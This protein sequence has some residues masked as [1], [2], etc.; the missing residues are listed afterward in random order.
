MAALCDNADGGTCRFVNDTV[1]SAPLAIWA[2]VLVCVDTL[3]PPAVTARD[4]LTP[5]S[6]YAP[7]FLNTTSM[8]RF[9]PTATVVAVVVDSGVE[10]PFVTA[11]VPMRAV[12]WTPAP[13][14]GV[15]SRW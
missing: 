13:L 10:T 14:D 12:P 4:T 1:L 15:P 3:S 8:T 9:G 7:E 6:G 5:T 2:T 11:F